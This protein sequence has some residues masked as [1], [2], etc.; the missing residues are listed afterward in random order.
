MLNIVVAAIKNKKDNRWLIIQ[1]KRGDYINKWALVGGKMEPGETI[2][3]A[4]EREIEEE[5]SLRVSA[6]SFKAL[7]NEKLI[8]KK[9]SQLIKHF[10]IFLFYATTEESREIKGGEEGKLKWVSIDELKRMKKEII[11]SDYFMLT[12]LIN[13]K[14][15]VL[16]VVEITMKQEKEKLEIERLDFVK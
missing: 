7:I 12:E 10:I 1:R 14:E 4:I 8:D 11:P 5:T 15:K 9:T 6:I 3:Q 13:T 2:I 16:K